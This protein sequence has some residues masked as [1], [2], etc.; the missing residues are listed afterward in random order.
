ML[1]PPLQGHVPFCP[2]LFGDMGKK[3]ALAA[4]AVVATAVAG[5]TAFVTTTDT[6]TGLLGIGALEA[7]FA[8]FFHT[9]YTYFN[10]HPE[11]PTLPTAAEG[12]ATFNRFIEVSDSHWCTQTW[13]RTWFWD[14][15]PQ[16]LCRGNIAD[17]VAYGFF[18]RTVAQMEAEGLAAMLERMVDQMSESSGLTFKE[19]PYEKL[20]FMSHIWEPVQASYFPALY[21]GCVICC[22]Q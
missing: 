10:R 20:P 9:C 5:L 11:Q 16:K 22:W 13:L 8:G 14:M 3:G 18:S 19:G 6:V 1:T 7:A 21:Y 15:E 12:K 2:Q 17:L 4:R